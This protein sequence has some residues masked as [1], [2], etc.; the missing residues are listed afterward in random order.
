L[1]IA[2]VIIGATEFVL[3]GQDKVLPDGGVPFSTQVESPSEVDLVGSGAAGSGRRVGGASFIGQA[4]EAIA[5]GQ[6][7]RAPIE[8]IPEW[9]RSGTP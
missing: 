8:I 7:Y 1:C 2:R 3:L 5:L 9:S 4:P 6:K